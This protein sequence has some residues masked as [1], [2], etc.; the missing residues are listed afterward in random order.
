MKDRLAH[1]MRENPQV[2]RAVFYEEVSDA[3]KQGVDYDFKGRIELDKIKDQA[4]LP[5]ADYYICGPLPFMKAQ[6]QSLKSLGVDPERI[7]ME[8]F[9]SVAE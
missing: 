1:I 7:H 8:V 6:S 9:G 3:D 4:V 2:S 5:D